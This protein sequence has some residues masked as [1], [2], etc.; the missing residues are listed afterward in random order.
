MW[1]NIRQTQDN[2]SIIQPIFIGREAIPIMY[3]KKN[4]AKKT[5]IPLVMPAKLRAMKISNAPKG[6]NNRSIIEPVTFAV[7]NAE[8]TFAKAFCN[9]LI[10]NNPGI[11]NVI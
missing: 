1:V 4:E 9:T 5:K 7:I 3:S 10:I 11:K 8:D 6:A 2:K